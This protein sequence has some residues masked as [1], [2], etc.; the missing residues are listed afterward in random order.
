MVSWADSLVVNFFDQNLQVFLNG[1]N[2]VFPAT[3]TAYVANVLAIPSRPEQKGNGCDRSQQGWLAGRGVHAYRQR[4]VRQRLAL[5]QNSE[6]DYQYM[7]GI[8]RVM[9]RIDEHRH[10]FDLATVTGD[11]DGDG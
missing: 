11:F 4:N 5:G 6:L 9:E 2:G 8:D 10:Y 1:G 3:G 7:G